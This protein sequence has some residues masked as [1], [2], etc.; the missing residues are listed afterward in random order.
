MCAVLAATMLGFSIAPLV[1]NLMGWRNKDYDLWYATG[2]L[3]LDG[4][5]I[6]PKDGRPFPF[7]YPPSCAAMLGIASLAGEHGFIILLLLLNSAAWLGSVVLAVYLATGRVRGL[8]PMLY[9]VPSLCVAPYIHDTYLLGQPNLLLLAW[10]L[11]AFACLR[12]GRP[13]SAGVLIALAAAVKAFP[14]LALG[15]LVYRRCWRATAAM[16]ATLAIL[17]VVLPLA[18]RTPP[19]MWDDLQTWTRGMVFKYDAGGI[20]QR[21][22]RCYSFKNQ[23]IMALGNRLLRSIPA[24][25]EDNDIWRV[26]VA[27]LDF[28]TVNIAIALGSLAICGAYLAAMPRPRHRTPETDAIET[29]MLLLMILFFSPLAF[30]Y[31]YVW[32]MYP[33]TVALKLVLDAPAGS[34]ERRERWAWLGMV[35]LILGLA[36]PFLKSAQAYGNLFF[37]GLL[38]MLGLGALMARRRSGVVTV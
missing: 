33:L 6:Y 19:Q 36:L 28:R 34:D 1:N 10:M 15:Y 32:L 31:F 2:R 35:L 18:F 23:S 5:T 22:E 37:A 14:V 8:N 16:L 7:M 24:D 20:A 27:N 13:N 29:A 25:G 11:A 12:L 3:V 4:G 9:V 26:N 30:N 17:L 38:L 21:P